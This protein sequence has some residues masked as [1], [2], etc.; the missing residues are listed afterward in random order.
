VKEYDKY[1]ITRI[2]VCSEVGIYISLIT[3]SQWRNF[4]CVL[5]CELKTLIKVYIKYVSK[6]HRK[7]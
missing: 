6:H 3:V 1:E 2:K 4:Q 5:V 7:M